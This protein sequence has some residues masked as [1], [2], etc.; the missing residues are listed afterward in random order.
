MRPCS[1]FC[2]D[3]LTKVDSQI[4]GD[5]MFADSFHSLDGGAYHPW[6]LGIF[7]GVR[8][9]SLARALQ[10]YPIFGPIVRRFG[11][12]AR[13]IAKEHEQNRLAAEKAMLRKSQGETPGGRRDFMTYML[14]KSRDGTPGFSDMEIIMNSPLLVTAGSET[15][16]TALSSLFWHLGQ[17]EFRP[18]YHMLKEEIRNAFATEDEID[19]KSTAALPYL[20]AVVEENLRIYPP[21]AETPPRV[22]PG[23]SV[24]DKFVPEGVSSYRPRFPGLLSFVLGNVCIFK[25]PLMTETDC[26]SVVQ[27]IVTV[28]QLATNHNPAN[29]ADPDSFRPE[30]WLPSTHPLYNPMFANDDRACFRPFSYGTRDCLGKNLAY[31]E[32]RVIISRILFRFDYE[33]EPGQEDWVEKAP[34]FVVWEKP[35]LNV[36]FRERK[37]EEIKA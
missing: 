33:L 34:I 13:L 7:E 28:Y 2:W 19:M 9:V 36:R 4:I 25:Q 16:A 10:Q 18:V 31:S 20:R 11:N 27:T 26:V 5:L 22:S 30:R 17:E 1:A 3:G 32:L 8:G 15:T 6:V 35:N 12:S 14:K 29:F 24:N 23:A 37:M 21:A